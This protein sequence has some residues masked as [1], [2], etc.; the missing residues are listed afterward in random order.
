MYY[1][2][3]EFTGFGPVKWH[4]LWAAG[5]EYSVAEEEKVGS[6][7]VETESVRFLNE[8][9]FWLRLWRLSHHSLENT[10]SYGF[11]VIFELFK[12]SGIVEINRRKKK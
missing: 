5:G 11:F 12:L 6:F 1:C 7:V 8:Q 9:N 2:D 10:F 4:S 3:V